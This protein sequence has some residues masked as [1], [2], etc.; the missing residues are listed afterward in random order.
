MINFGSLARAAGGD[1]AATLEELFKQLDRKATHTG[2]RSAQLAALA[3]LDQQIEHKDVILKLSTGS[4]KTVLGLLYA[5]MMRRKYK[6]EPVVYLCPTNQL[7]DQVVETGKLIGVKVSAFPSKG[8]PYD[9][10]S[11][12]AVLAC[13]YDRLFNAN[14]VFENQSIRPSAVIM[15]DVHAGA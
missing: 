8:L 7:A 5:E 10:L 2:L 1:V 13:T 15:D 9:A 14:S 11:G 12:D 6:G 4:G 3:A